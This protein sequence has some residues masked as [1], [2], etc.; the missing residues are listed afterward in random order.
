MKPQDREGLLRT[1]A[2][3]FEANESRP[4]GVAWADVRTRI[5]GN[6]G[7]SKALMSMESTGAESY[8]AAR[9]FRGRLDV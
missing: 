6:A 1:L 2:K 3:R 7:A 9:G 5:E 4:P 8:Y